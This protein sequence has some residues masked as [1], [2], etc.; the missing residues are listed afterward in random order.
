MEVTLSPSEDRDIIYVLLEV[1]I[2]HMIGIGEYVG[3]I[4]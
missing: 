3:N 4:L 2:L 1:Q